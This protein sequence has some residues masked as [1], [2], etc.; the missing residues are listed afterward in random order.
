MA[1]VPLRYCSA[2][3]DFR[4]LIIES[5]EMSIDADVSVIVL[6]EQHFSVTVRRDP[7]F[8]HVAV[9]YR[10]DFVSFDAVR[11]DVDAAMK[12]GR[13]IF[14]KR[15]SYSSACL[16]GPNILLL[17]NMKG[18][19]T[20]RWIRKCICTAM[21]GIAGQ[22]GG[23]RSN[24]ENDDSDTGKYKRADIF[25][26]LLCGPNGMGNG[27]V[28]D[29]FRNDSITVVYR[30]DAFRSSG[31]NYIARFQC[32]ERRNIFNHGR[33]GK[34]HIA[35]RSL[36][37]NGRIHSASDSQFVR[38]GNIRFR[39]DIR[40]RCGRIESFRNRPRISFSFCFILNVSQCHIQSDAITQYII[41]GMSCFNIFSFTADCNDQF[42]FMMRF[43]RDV[44]D[45]NIFAVG[46]NCS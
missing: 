38:V 34:Y 19:K 46:E 8:I 29:K 30:S 31:E 15:G 24:Q 43:M 11:A 21:I 4:D 27:D 33:N 13:S 9:A 16:G 7:D 35:G 40:D 18:I 6:D 32:E 3:N 37:P 23:K 25:H 22:R 41:I 39:N 12:V 36:L 14:G 10:D 1:Y 44:R 28:S 42:D 45:D 26:A 20:R 2:P 5:F 17:R